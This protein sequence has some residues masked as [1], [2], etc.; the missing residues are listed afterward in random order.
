MRTREFIMK[1]LYSFARSDAE[2]DVFYKDMSDAY[3]R[4]FDRLGIGEWTYM[5]WASGGAF[6]EFSHEFQTI[7]DAGEDIIYIH[8]GKKIA[9][10]EEVMTDEVMATVGVKREE[11]EQV[12]AA[13]VGNIFNLGT[14][15]SVPLELNFTDEDG[16]V[17]PVVMGSYGI[18]PA[19]VMGVIVERYADEKG[20][21]WPA[22]IAPADV[23]LVRL[24]DDPAVVKAADKL[25]EDLKSAGKDVL[26]DDRDESVGRKFADADLIG[27]PVRLTVSKRTLEQ[28][29]VELKHRNQADEKMMKI[30]DVITVLK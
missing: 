27:V 10:N 4:I 13:E 17:K 6:A 2:H 18:G 22:N 12:K 15:K 8:K 26:Y 19:R 23:H 16:K 29:S 3:V 14:T 21:V 24:G 20:L 1:D 7:T 5:T 30:S 9:I 11:L 28:E 25:F